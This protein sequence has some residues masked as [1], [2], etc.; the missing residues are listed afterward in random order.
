MVSAPV[1]C[2]GI[3]QA[4]RP[5]RPQTCRRHSVGR[6]GG[7]PAQIAAITG[8]KTLTEVVRYTKTADQI[9]MAKE[10]AELIANRK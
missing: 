7:E 2:R 10:A 8:H 6:G 1:Q 3:A 4:L 5:A 9:R